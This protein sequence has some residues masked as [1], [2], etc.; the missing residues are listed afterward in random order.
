[1]AT[2]K[3]RSEG[4]DITSA[5]LLISTDQPHISNCNIDKAPQNSSSQNLTL[6]VKDWRDWTYTDGSLQRNEVGQDT[7][8]GVPPSLKCFPQCK[9]K[10]HGYNQHHLTCRAS[11]YSSCSRTRLLTY[12]HRQ[13][14]YITAPGQKQLSHPNL[15][16][17]HIQGDV[18][19]SIAKTIRQS[20]LRNMPTPLLKVS[21]H[22]LR[23]R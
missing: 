5:L 20:P 4:Q 17:H 23:H 15:H 12:S 11:S 2:L 18:L 14:Y 7:G 3:P 13:S 16:R 21:R 1:M 22:L 8:S 9:P 6:E 10:R 19:Q